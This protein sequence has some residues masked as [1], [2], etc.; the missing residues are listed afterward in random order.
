MRTNKTGGLSL[1][2][3]NRAG[4]SSYQAAVADSRPGPTPSTTVTV[5]LT[6]SVMTRR[7][8]GVVEVRIGLAEFPRPQ[9]TTS[10]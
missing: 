5:K 8:E 9:R 6:R 4:G 10:D 2:S 3:T 1:S 7:T